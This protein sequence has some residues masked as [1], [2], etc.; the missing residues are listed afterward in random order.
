MGAVGSSEGVVD[1]EVEGGG[2][3]PTREGEE[4]T[5]VKHGVEVDK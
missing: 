3:L 5:G 1:E 4:Q 2:E